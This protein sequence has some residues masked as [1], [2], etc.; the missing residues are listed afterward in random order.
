IP[1]PLCRSCRA[2]T[3]RHVTRSSNRKGNAGRPYYK[4]LPCNK[5]HC[6]ADSRGCDP[7]NPNCS[8]GQ[9]SRM[10]VAGRERNPPGGLHFVCQ[11][12]G[13]D[14][15]LPRVNDNGVHERV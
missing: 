1:P 15:Y 12:G 6:F 9:P 14:F 11:N 10:Q 4:C 8:C 7:R 3:T 13:C 2:P 5:F